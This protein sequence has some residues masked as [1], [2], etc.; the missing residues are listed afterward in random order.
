MG[1]AEKPSQ[2]KQTVFVS[3]RYNKKKK[4]GEHAPLVAGI[5]KSKH[6]TA[7]IFKA[8]KAAKG[9]TT[10]IIKLGIMKASAKLHLLRGADGYR[11]WKRP[12]RYVKYKQLVVGCWPVGYNDNADIVLR[13]FVHVWRLMC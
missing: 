8:L 3:Y 5:S 11:F 2:N 1:W 6:R 9:G 13:V 10:N 4:T 7:G 12:S